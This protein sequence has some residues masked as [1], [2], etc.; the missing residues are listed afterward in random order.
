[1]VN[2]NNKNSDQKQKI[3]PKGMVCRQ[4]FQLWTRCCLD[5]YCRR[6]LQW[7][8]R[9]KTNMFLKG[10]HLNKTCK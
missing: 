3:D 6:D 7:Y 8:Y 5:I 4:C 2:M 10:R 9:L 1:M